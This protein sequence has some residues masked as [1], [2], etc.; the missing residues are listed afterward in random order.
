MNNTAHTDEGEWEGEHL[1]THTH[2]LSDMHRIFCTIDYWAGR[3]GEECTLI[4]STL[5]RNA[6][7]GNPEGQHTP[8]TARIFNN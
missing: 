1:G 8:S 3:A 5:G 2:T 6:Q 7:Q 4:G